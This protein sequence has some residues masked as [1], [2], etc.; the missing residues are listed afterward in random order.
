MWFSKHLFLF[1]TLAALAACGFT[2]VY[3]P[4]G[5]GKGLNGAILVSEPSDR[6]AF[7]FVGRLEERLGQPQS[8][9]YK[10]DYK[11][12]TSTIG[13]GI[14]P[15]QETTRYNLFGKVDYSITERA[16]GSV[17]ATGTVDNFTGYSA[18][19]LI[20]GTQSVTRDANQRLMVILADQI[21]ARLI[22]TAPDWQQ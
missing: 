6:N 5:A 7:I 21:V 17:V 14:T 8:A 15:E 3:G 19:S 9:R 1:A 12:T 18:T 2:P 16:T 20:V 4:N 10:L 22:A 11:I 13:V